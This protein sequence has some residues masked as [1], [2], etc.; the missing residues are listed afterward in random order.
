MKPF[1]IIIARHSESL[2]WLNYLPKAEKRNYELIVSNSGEKADFPNADKVILRENLGRE[3]GHY[4]DYF[5]NERENM[6]ETLVLI[7]A[8]PWPHE[9]PEILLELFYGQPDFPFDMSFL[10]TDQPV[11]ILAVHKWTVAEHIFKAGWDGRNWPE[12]RHGGKP[13]KIGGG[14]QFYIKKE[15]VLRRPPEHYTKIL[16]TAE[17]PDCKL[18]HVLEFHWP[19][20]FKLT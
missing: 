12:E 13:W 20:A 19:N 5:A 1:Q 9:K 2:N 11:A 8:D 6:A 3:A 10:G 17:D 15:I 16:K 14:A 4:L 18:A 7:Q